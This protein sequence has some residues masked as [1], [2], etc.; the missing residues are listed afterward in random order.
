MLLSQGTDNPLVAAPA[1][2]HRAETGLTLVSGV[3]NVLLGTNSS[4]VN[5]LVQ[6]RQKS[7]VSVSL[8]L[9]I[10]TASS[11]GCWD[12]LASLLMRSPGRGWQQFRVKSRAYC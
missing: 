5:E 11:S 12:E 6:R 1:L 10:S 8:K 2:F 4:F 9:S 7:I 3:W